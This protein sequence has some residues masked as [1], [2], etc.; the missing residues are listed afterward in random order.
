V[1]TPRVEYREGSAPT[2]E[3]EARLHHAAHEECFI[4]NSVK[5]AIRVA[6]R[7]EP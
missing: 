7:S 2:P 5:T 1:L 4:S 6:P 3:D